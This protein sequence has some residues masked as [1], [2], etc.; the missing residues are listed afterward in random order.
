VVAEPVIDSHVPMDVTPI[1][2]SPMAEI[3]EELEHVFQEPIA[4]HEEEQQ[5][6]LYRMCHTM[7]LLKDLRGPEG[8][9]SLMTTRFMLEKKIKWRVIPPLLK[10]P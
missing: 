3:D 2:D 5:E 1:V 8:Q 10:K 4:N 9:L 6:P 7:N